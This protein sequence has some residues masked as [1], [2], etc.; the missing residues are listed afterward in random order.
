MKYFTPELYLRFNS[1]DVEE[2]ER[3]DE[4]WDRAE[5]EY[6][7]RLASIR[8]RMPSPVR[9][10]Y[11]QCLHDALVFSPEEQHRPEG[12]FPPWWTAVGIVSVSHMDEIV[13]LNYCLSDHVVTKEAPQG[14]RFSKVQEQ[15]LY[16]EVDMLD[17]RRGPFVHRILLSTGVTLEIPFASVI[18]H[19]FKAPVVRKAAKQSA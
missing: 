14:W 9:A 8:E 10:L 1:F 12:W 6:K 18:I 15:W 16:D 7:E 11:E 13:S 3:A 4:E 17:D 19:R 5:A 2:A